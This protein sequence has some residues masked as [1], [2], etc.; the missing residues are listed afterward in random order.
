MR[1]QGEE[2]WKGVEVRKNEKYERRETKN[3]TTGLKT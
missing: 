1:I 2:V 3:K